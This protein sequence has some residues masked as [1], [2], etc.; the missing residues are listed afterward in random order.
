[1]LDYAP[2]LAIDACALSFTPG[3]LTDIDTGEPGA[4][5]FATPSSREERGGQLVSLSRQV[6]FENVGDPTFDSASCAGRF[7][8][9]DLVFVTDGR[10]ASGGYFLPA[11]FKGEGLIVT[12]G[13]LLGEPMAMGRASSGASLPVSNWTSIPAGI[14]AATEGE[15]Q[16]EGELRAFVRPMDA[17]M[18]MLGVYRE[19]GTTLHIDNPDCADLHANVWTDLP[20]SDGFVYERVLE[21]VDTAPARF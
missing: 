17:R 15:I 19:D 8:G 10:N 14:E 2:A 20:G 16:F 9:R 21:T 3:C 18:E 13:G 7:Q 1:M 5:W 11:A 12:T 6:A 4:D